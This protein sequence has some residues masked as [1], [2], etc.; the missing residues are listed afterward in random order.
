MSIQLN[1]AEK[2]ELRNILSHPLMKRVFS[3]ALVG[4]Y[5]DKA[6]AASLEQCAMAYNYTEGARGILNR[7]LNMGEIKEEMAANVNQRRFRPTVD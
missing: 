3:E 1:T 6:G 7:I 4:T 2:E 5:R